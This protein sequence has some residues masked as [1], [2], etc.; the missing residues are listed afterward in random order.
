VIKMSKTATSADTSVVPLIDKPNSLLQRYAWR[1]S[2]KNL[3]GEIGDPVRAIAHHSGVML[4]AGAME[5]TVAKRWNALDPHLRWLAI[6][7]TS[8]E[9]GCSW[10]IDFG[11][12]EAMQ[13][14]VDP[15]KVRDV[16]RWRDSDAY[17]ERERIVL[18]YAQAA[19]ATP[20]VIS[21]ELSARLNEHFSA[22]EIVELAAWVALENYRS[23]VNAGLRLHSQGF[24]A[25]CDVTAVG[26]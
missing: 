18:E 26:R 10:C 6:Q 9:I 1:Y 3:G 21:D 7:A 24:A 8:A 25:K 17:D 5:M 14:G 22:E 23:R 4:A 19:T 11:Y 12:Y 15:R 16:P 20:V 2:R 13:D